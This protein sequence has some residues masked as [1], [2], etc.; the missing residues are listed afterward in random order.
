MDKTTTAHEGVQLG[1]ALKEGSWVKS[2]KKRFFI[3]RV[4]TPSDDN[5]DGSTHTL[6]YFTRVPKARLV[7]PPTTAAYS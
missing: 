3:L 2:W 4:V 5:T 6:A 1:W 7:L